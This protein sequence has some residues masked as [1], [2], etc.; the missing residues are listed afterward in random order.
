MR[1]EVGDSSQNLST[2]EKRKRL[3]QKSKSVKHQSMRRKSRSHNDDTDRAQTEDNRIIH[4]NENIPTPL[5]LTPISRSRPP[6]IDTNDITSTQHSLLSATPTP[7]FCFL[8]VHAF[9]VIF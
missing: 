8:K 3:M 7:Q 2:S 6:E 9:F 4:T 5:G 1:I